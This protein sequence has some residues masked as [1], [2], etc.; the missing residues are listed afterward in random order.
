MKG[1]DGK[2]SIREKFINKKLNW[3]VG[4]LEP[5]LL[6]VRQL[7]QVPVKNKGQHRTWRSDDLIF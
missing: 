2:K 3:W 4:G 5:L 1:E 7:L 6:F